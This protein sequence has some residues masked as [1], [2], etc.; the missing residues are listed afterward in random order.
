MHQDIIDDL[1]NTF[2]YNA[3]TGVI[4]YKVNSGFKV[5]VGNVCKYI[6]PDGY[7]QISR[8]FQGKARKYQGH[9]LAWI[10][11]T[12]KAPP[13]CI[14]HINRLRTDNR[15]CNLRGA[16]RGQ[17][18][19]NGKTRRDNSHGMRGISWQKNC[20]RW[21][22]RVQLNGVVRRAFFVSKDDAIQWVT[23]KRAELFGEHDPKLQASI[24]SASMGGA[25]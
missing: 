18:I 3:D 13:E 20:S 8:K 9:R 22:A 12:G 4:S 19:L 17:N 10:L 6:S 15:W 5:R 14:D 11:K 16:T 23:A 24:V 2:N 21:C 25:S 1:R 7:I